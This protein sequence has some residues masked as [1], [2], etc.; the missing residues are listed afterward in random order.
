MK[1]GGDANTSRYPGS[2]LL[3]Y[4]VESLIIEVE[5]KAVNKARSTFAD[6][7]T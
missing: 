2:F 5:V 1:E 6:R 4:E 3:H 7:L